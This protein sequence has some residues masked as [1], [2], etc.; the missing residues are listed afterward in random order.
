MKDIPD[1][2]IDL[3]L[4]DPP[5]LISKKSGF[6]SGGAWTNA[7]DKRLQKTPPKTDFGEW[8]KKE[9]DFFIAFKEFYRVLK[10]IGALICFFD[11]WKMQYLK[12]IAEENKFKQFRLIRWDKT[13]PVPVNSK[14]NYLSNATEYA[15]TCVKGGKPTFHSEYNPGIFKYPI[16][17]GKERTEHPTQK[18]VSLMRDLLGIH[19]NE[20]DTVLDA[21]MGSGST[22]IACIHTNR[23]FI[24]IELDENYFKI[25]KDRIESELNNVPY[26]KNSTH[27]DIKNEKVILF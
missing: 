2:S 9:I 13:N 10:P 3:I 23:N 18:P 4:T 6:N 15:L 24:G 14:L 26:V 17:S 1:E 12:Q 8:D 19:T 25:A 11:I 27:T 20:G 5:Y 16:C 21:F 7:E 22:G